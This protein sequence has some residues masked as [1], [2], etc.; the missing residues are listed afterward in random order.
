[1]W[2]KKKLKIKSS[3]KNFF[4]DWFSWHWFDIFSS[5]NWYLFFQIILTPTNFFYWQKI[6]QCY[7]KKRYSRPFTNFPPI[8]TQIKLPD[9]AYIVCN[10]CVKWHLSPPTPLFF[11]SDLFNMILWCAL[12]LPSDKLQTFTMWVLVRVE[13]IFLGVKRDINI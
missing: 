8:Q 10:C 11:S 2:R 5:F 4:S 12:V 1:M 9:I 3:F 6:C 13:N 7:T